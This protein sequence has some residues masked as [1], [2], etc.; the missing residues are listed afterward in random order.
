[1]LKEEGES[2]VTVYAAYYDAFQVCVAHGDFKMMLTASRKY[3]AS[4]NHHKRTG[5]PAPR[6]NGDR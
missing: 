1:L 2:D 5:L 4:F 6:T 3:D